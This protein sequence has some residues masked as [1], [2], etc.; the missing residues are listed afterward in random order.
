[1]RLVTEETRSEI[2]RTRLH[3]KL[4]ES[5]FVVWALDLPLLRVRIETLVAGRTVV[6]LGVPPTL[7]HPAQVVLV[8][9]LTC[10]ALLT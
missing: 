2:G 1:M 3:T 7:G 8:K 9:E 10:V 6:V 5:S 4:A